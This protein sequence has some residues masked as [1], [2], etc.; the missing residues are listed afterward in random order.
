MF[1]KKGK[2]AMNNT[3]F[4]PFFPTEYSLLFGCKNITFKGEIKPQ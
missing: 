1:K 3:Y 4:R 2:V